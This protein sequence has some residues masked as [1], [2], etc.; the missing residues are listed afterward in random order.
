MRRRAGGMGKGTW[1]RRAGRLTQVPA[2]RGWR[3]T[4]GQ[5]SWLPD[6]PNPGPSRT[7]NPPGG[8]SAACSGVFRFRTRSQWRGPRRFCTGFPLRR[9]SHRGSGGNGCSAGS[10]AVTSP[11]SCQ[12]RAFHGGRPKAFDT[13]K[14]SAR[15]YRRSARWPGLTRRPAAGRAAGI[16]NGTG[17]GQPVTAR[18]RYAAGGG[19]SWAERRRR[20]ERQRPMAPPATSAAAAA[21]V[22]PPGGSGRRR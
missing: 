5:V 4:V 13:A 14:R 2:P 3:R 20:R 15:S 17:R 22:T 9:G 8:G 16:P 19:P 11:S 10:L 1:R 21:A 12:N 6:L 18:L 7:G